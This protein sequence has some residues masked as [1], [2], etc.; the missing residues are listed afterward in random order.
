[1]RLRLKIL[2][3]A[4]LGVLPLVALFYWAEMSLAGEEARISRTAALLLG[5]AL[6][7]LSVGL[8]F[9]FLVRRRLLGLLRGTEKLATAGPH[10]SSDDEIGELAA[11]LAAA[12]ENVSGK[13]SQLRQ[14]TQQRKNVEARVR[15]IEERYVLAVRGSNDGLWEWNLKNDQAYFS[16]RWKAMLGY[17][18]SE[19][20]N[21]IDEWR[22]RIHPENRAGR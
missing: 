19:I 21:H 12:Q 5:V 1:M 2:A 15:E 17:D 14:E 22:K 3:T 8:G 4:L 6:L 7:L 18:E 10:V 16:P 20:G 13:E 9:E 11:H